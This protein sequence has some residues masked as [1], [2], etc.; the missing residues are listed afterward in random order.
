MAR[1]QK[2]EGSIISFRIPADKPRDY[3][4]LLSDIVSLRRSVQVF[5]GVGMAM[6]QFNAATGNG[7]ISKF[8]I[9]DQ[10]GDWFDEDGFG[11]AGEEDLKKISIPQNLKPNL[12]G[13][14]AHLEPDEHLLVVM[15]YSQGNSLSP[16]QVEKFLRGIVASEEIV[17]RYGAV[18]VDVFKD[19]HQIEQMLEIDTLKEVKI[20]IR[21][22]NHIPPGLIREI[23]EELAAENA[24]EMQRTIKA[25]TGSY[26]EP[27]NRTR[28]FGAM[29]AENGDL[30]VK[31]DEEGAVV[32]RTSA[33]K[34]L[35]K[36]VVTDDPKATPAGA[37]EKIK[38][39]LID[40]VKSNRK[41]AEEAAAGK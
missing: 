37:F 1:K 15:T 12:V 29:A 13:F 24:S 18:Q 2:Y 22:P 21:R 40:R 30:E 20:T 38:R 5:K 34:P 10:K 33:S 41:R 27:G 19:S 9:I 25:E 35:R 3:A 36:V 28:A 17:S 8:S 11:P 32:K 31:Y 4:A 26:L 14:P 16:L 39:F 23:E 7:T 6:T